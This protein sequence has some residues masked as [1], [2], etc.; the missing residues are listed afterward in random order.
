LTRYIETTVGEPETLF[1][2]VLIPRRTRLSAE[3]AKKRSEEKISFEGRIWK[4]FE[5]SF[6]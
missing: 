5:K 2:A 1:S 3:V 4:G 6:L